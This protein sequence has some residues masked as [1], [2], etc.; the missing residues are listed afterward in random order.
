MILFFRASNF[1]SL[2]DEVAVSLVAAPLKEQRDA[3]IDCS[4]TNHGIV[5]VIALYGANAS[6]KS[7]TLQILSFLRWIVKRS[8]TTADNPGTG[9]RHFALDGGSS[10]NT[11]EVEIGFVH[12]GVRYEFGVRLTKD[13]IVSEWLYQYPNKVRQTLYVRDSGE[14]K[15]GRA[16]AGANRQIQSITKKNVLFLSAAHASGHA[17]LTKVFVFF[18]SKIILRFSD[19]I[20]PSFEELMGL[21]ADK[22]L[23]DKVVSYLRKADTGISSLKIERKPLSES[24]KEG[25]NSLFDILK[26][27]SGEDIPDAVLPYREESISIRLGHLG[28]D[29]KIK[30][31]DISSESQGTRYLLKLVP[32]MIFALEQG[33]TLVLDEITTSLHT[34]LARELVIAFNNPKINSKGA[35]LIFTTHDT[36]LLQPGLLRRDEVWFAEK[37][38]EGVTS[39]FP[40]TDIKTKNTDNI[41][42]GYVH[43]RFGA[44]PYIDETFAH[45]E[46]L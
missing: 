31:L 9:I 18:D 14:Y 36:N 10:K 46:D 34:L 40:L 45:F 37:S 33:A 7:N 2:R 4:Y 29:K 28:V 23:Q 1:L 6:G 8:F 5:P 44:V 13:E 12:E 21:D 11:S 26:K 3:L 20:D 41:E 35:Q 32:L 15:F 24:T 16:L 43:G 25:V 17:Q 27:Y 39:V 42:K 38:R 30:Y 19:D 22:N